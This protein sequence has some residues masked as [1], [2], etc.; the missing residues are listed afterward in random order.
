[1][2]QGGRKKIK[3]AAIKPAGK[4]RLNIR[5]LKASKQIKKKVSRKKDDRKRE[6][7]P[8]TLKAKS[9]KH[10]A[11]NVAPKK[12]SGKPKEEA[13]ATSQRKNSQ[14]KID[15]DKRLIMWTGVTFFMLL[16]VVVWVFSMKYQLEQ[17]RIQ[18]DNSDSSQDWREL[19]DEVGEKMAEI[20]SGFK[21]IKSFEQ[22]VEPGVFPK[23]GSNDSLFST[24][25]DDVLDQN[26]IEELIDLLKDESGTTSKSSVVE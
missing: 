26:G 8:G 5:V 1:M 6:L 7:M 22:N 24:S 2:T 11:A 13:A 14:E 21:K 18:N 4:K 20:I 9:V 16:I 10:K 25:T 19:S 3:K 15:R 17:V 23:A 12:T